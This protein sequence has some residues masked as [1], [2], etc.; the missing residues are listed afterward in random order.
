MHRWMVLTVLTSSLAALAAPTGAAAA[1]D[2]TNI[3]AAPSAAADAKRVT[4]TTEPTTV[5]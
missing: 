2:V 5:S 3:G 4:L 1:T